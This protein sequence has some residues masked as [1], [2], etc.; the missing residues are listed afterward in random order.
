[1]KTHLILIIVFATLFTVTGCFF[2]SP[3]PPPIS[4]DELQEKQE[5]TF[6]AGFDK[7]WDASLVAL[8]G[9]AVGSR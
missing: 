3:K 6:G 8:S 4:W 1:M 7:V 9:A 5:A 2:F